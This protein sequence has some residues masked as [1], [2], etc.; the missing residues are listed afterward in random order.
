MTEKTVLLQSVDP[1][2]TVAFTG[3]RPQKIME[4]VNS[5]MTKVNQQYDYN[6]IYLIILNSSLYYLIFMPIISLILDYFS[7]NIITKNYQKYKLI[8]AED[9][10]KEIELNSKTI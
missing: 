10:K 7:F 9:G 2:R 5:R 6:T 1:A 3:Y 8:Y 4:S